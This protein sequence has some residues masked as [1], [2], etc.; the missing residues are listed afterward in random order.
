MTLLDFPG[1]RLVGRSFAS[2]SSG[3][4]TEAGV[5]KGFIMVENAQRWPPPREAS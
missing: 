3:G 1:L 4:V 2:G 5:T